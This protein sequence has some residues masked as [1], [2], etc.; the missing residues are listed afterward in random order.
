M[1]GK[2]FQYEIRGELS[3]VGLKTVLVCGRVYDTE[4]ESDLTVMPEQERSLNIP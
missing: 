4:T 3:I 2:A 1:S